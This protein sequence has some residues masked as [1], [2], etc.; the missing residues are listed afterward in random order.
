MTVLSL[1]SSMCPI[2]LYI[3]AQKVYLSTAITHSFL[4]IV[5][6]VLLFNYFRVQS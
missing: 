5:P 1:S 3:L 4:T 2:A 6:T